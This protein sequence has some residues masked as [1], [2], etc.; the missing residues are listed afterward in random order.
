MSPIVERKIFLTPATHIESYGKL[1]KF[2]PSLPNFP[3]WFRR[4]IG[5]FD[6]WLFH[7]ETHA[8]K[9]LFP[10]FPT[11]QEKNSRFAAIDEATSWFPDD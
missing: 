8:R 10:T 7:S 6:D 9:V 3:N 11:N 5:T 2:G 1:D 4:R